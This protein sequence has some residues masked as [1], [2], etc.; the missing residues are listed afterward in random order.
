MIKEGFLKIQLLISNIETIAKSFKIKFAS[1]FSISKSKSRKT[2]PKGFLL[3]RRH[4]FCLWQKSHEIC[5]Y[6]VEV[7]EIVVIKEK[8]TILQTQ[9]RSGKK[10]KIRCISVGRR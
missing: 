7:Y 6:R 10:E 4:S 1:A 8:L 5:C 2:S 3:T 9:M